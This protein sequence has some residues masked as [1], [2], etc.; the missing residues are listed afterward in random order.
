MKWR[1]KN[2]PGW[3]VFG[4][5]GVSGLRSFIKNYI[6]KGWKEPIGACAFVP[7]SDLRNDNQ[8]WYIKEAIKTY[9]EQQRK[10]K[11]VNALL[12]L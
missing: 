10:E 3:S 4:K 2:I 7:F 11:N 6:P 12:C 8:P 1:Q 9:D 5:K